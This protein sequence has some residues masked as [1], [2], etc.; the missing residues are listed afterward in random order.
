MADAV[1][2]TKIADGSIGNADLAINS[3]ASNNIVNGQILNEDISGTTAIAATKLESIVMTESENVSL[4]INDAGYLTS[5]SSA[6]ITDGEIT[7][8]DI[9]AVA[10]IAGTKVDPNFGGQ[11][12]QTAGTV[13]AGSFVGDGTLLTGVP[14]VIAPGTVTTAE[15]ATG[16]VDSDRILNGTIGVIDMASVGN[17]LVLT[18]NGVGNV[19]WAPQTNF[20]Q[21][22]AG[23]PYDDAS[24]VLGFSTVQGAIQQLDFI[25]DGADQNPGDDVTIGASP[26][27]GDISG[28]F[29]TGLTINAN[30][31]ASPQIANNAVTDA[32]LDKVNIPLS[33]FGLPT[34]DIDFNNNKLVNVGN[35]I[36]NQDVATKLYVDGAIASTNVL[37][38]GNILVGSVSNVA[39]PVALSGAATISNTGVLTL[40][41]NIISSSNIID[42]SVDAV[43]ITSGGINQVLTTDGA[44]TVLWAPQSSLPVTIG[45][46]SVNTVELADNSVTSIKIADGE[47]TDS[48]I[49]ATAGIAASKLEPIVMTESENISLLSN[50]AGYITSVNTAE[51]ADNAVTSVK[52]ADGTIDPVDMLSLGNNLVLTTDGAGVVGWVPQNA[53][54]ATVATDGTLNGNGDGIPLSVV[55]A[56]ANTADAIVSRDGT[57]SFA[58][59]N[60]TVD[61]LLLSGAGNVDGRDVSTDGTNQDALQTASGILAGGTD[62]GDLSGS[63]VTTGATIRQALE[64]L[65]GAI[66]GSPNPAAGLTNGFLP[67]SDGT[68]VLLDAPLFFDGT[69]NLGIGTLAPATKLHLFEGTNLPMIQTV[70]VGGADINQQAG[71]AIMSQA[72]NNETYS[73]PGTKG[74][75]MTARGNSFSDATQ[76]NDLIFSYSEGSGDLNLLKLDHQG[77]VGINTNDPVSDLQIQNTGH[78]FMDGVDLVLSSNVH[79]AA[80]TPTFTENGNAIALGLSP[81]GGLDLLYAAGGIMGTTAPLTPLFSVNTSGVASVSNELSVVNNIIAGGNVD[82][83]GD[84]IFADNG[85][86]K[87]IVAPNN[88]SGADGFDLILNGSDGDTGNDGGNIILRPGSGNSDGVIIPDGDMVFSS[89]GNRELRVFDEPTGTVKGDDL[90]ITAG[91]ANVGGGQDGGNLDLAPGNG[92]GAGA[93]G[94]VRVIGDLSIVHDGATAST[95]NF[96]GGASGENVVGIKGPNSTGPGYVLT[97]PDSGPAAGQVLTVLDASGSLDWTTPAGFSLPL[98]DAASNLGAVFDITNT[99]VD[100]TTARFSNLSASNAEPALRVFNQDGNPGSGGSIVL[101]SQDSGPADA[102]S[103]DAEKVS[104]GPL[105]ADFVIKTAQSGILTEA[106]RISAAT[107]VTI[108]SGNLD[109]ANNVSVT[110][111]LS[112]DGGATVNGNLNMPGGNLGVNTGAPRGNLDINGSVYVKI[113]NLDS[114]GAVN[115]DDFHIHC[116]GSVGGAFTIGLPASDASQVGRKLEFSSQN[117]GGNATYFLEPGPSTFLFDGQSVGA[118]TVSPTGAGNF[119]YIELILIRE[120]TWLITSRRVAE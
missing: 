41:T 48:D 52:I 98:T 30:S 6:D 82:V 12:I 67:Y 70:A 71:F 9:S 5:V 24:S 29:S 73:Q 18:T 101:E 77:F 103:L 14:A 69:D 56:S 119:S 95:I 53:L 112:A 85:A 79:F 26:A 51:L 35:P 75:L 4:L 62:I 28:N 55:S 114:S 44:G 93:D 61:N 20:S 38:N 39:Q 45:P 80:S 74:W 43:D 40:Q 10:A 32:K 11:N 36:N 64:E 57:G 68:G 89:G 83:G 99:A 111:L 66:E 2:G 34:A 47:I 113:R 110:G 76:Q 15:L 72:G 108:A 104:G 16:A 46:G 106:V 94:L 96:E 60:I 22:A 21:D 25:L 92:D 105:N 117:L 13:T 87:Q 63:L 81:A 91:S 78:L 37:N 3:I 49:N 88:T 23:I 27:G 65:E 19:V 31:I 118:P 115:P 97:L 58:A 50:D 86:N 100:Q 59:A 42:G 84:L 17:N 120:N 102:V 54:A 33:G 107:G 7:N 109:V 116:D 1:D 90:L 8:L